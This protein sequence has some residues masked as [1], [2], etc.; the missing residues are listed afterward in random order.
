MVSGAMSKPEHLS[1]RAGPRQGFGS[2][3][4]VEWELLDKAGRAKMVSV[5]MSKLGHLSDRKS[6]VT[7]VDTP[8]GGRRSKDFRVL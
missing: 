5:A 7:Q 1:R 2:H 3:R 4:G 8:Q 6:Y